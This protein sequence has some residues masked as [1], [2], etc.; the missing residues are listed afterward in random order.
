LCA[1]EHHCDVPVPETISCATKSFAAENE[2]RDISSKLL[3]EGTV[4]IVIGYGAHGPV[5]VTRPEEADRLVWNNHCFSNLTTYLK[6][7]EVKALGK[8][9]VVV[10]PCDAKSL[11]VLEAESQ[12]ER[13]NVYVIG[14]ACEGV[15]QPKCAHC[16]A[17]MPRFADVSLG[18]AAGPEPQSK[19]SPDRFAALMALNPEERFAFW[20][21]EFDRCVKCY[22]CRRS[23]ARGAPTSARAGR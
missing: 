14:M 18:A 16:T 17:R 10:K 9:A 12:L 3:R 11:V 5:V 21:E 8:A 1:D 20:S 7:K 19:S 6:R 15:G 13:K 22:A 4:K 23:A 2:L